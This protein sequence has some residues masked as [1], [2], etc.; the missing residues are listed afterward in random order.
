MTPRLSFRPEAEA[1][2]LAGRD[3]YEG[4]SPG[5]GAEFVK[6]LEVTIDVIVARPESF[7]RIRGAIRHAVLR[8]FPYSVLF[9]YDD[10]GI[11]ILN[12][13][14]HRRDPRRWRGA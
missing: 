12:I 11:L 14:H 2:A 3:W 7:P 13:H 1:E 9:T 8:R 5:L 10:E 6:V 4:G